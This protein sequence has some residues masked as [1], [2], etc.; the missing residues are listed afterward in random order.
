MFYLYF[1][2]MPSKI[3]F[4]KLYLAALGILL[5]FYIY[6]Q[7]NPESYSFFPQCPFHY[8]TGLDCPGCGS[9]RAVFCLLH[10][11]ITGAIHQNLLLVASL[12]LL[13]IHAGYHVTSLI[14][15]RKYKWALLYHRLTP[16]VVGV[17][18]VAFFIL[19]N[20]P[21]YPFKH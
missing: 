3:R 8:L 7:F 18:T 19:R 20:L 14:Y 17:I 21:S 12:P 13:A 11:D 4:K 10:G 16:I 2:T 15:D 5:L 6:Y 9:Q 1:S